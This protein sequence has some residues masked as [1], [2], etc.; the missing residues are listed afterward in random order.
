MIENYDLNPDAYE[1]IEATHRK[2][3]TTLSSMI[4]VLSDAIILGTNYEDDGV[5]RL[6]AS[7]YHLEDLELGL[8]SCDELDY[9]HCPEHLSIQEIEAILSRCKLPQSY[10][11]LFVP[12]AEVLGY[13]LDEGNLYSVGAARL[14]AVIL[15][16]MTFCGF[17]EATIDMER[18]KLDEAAAEAEKHRLLPPEEQ[19]EYFRSADEVFAEM[20][21]K[22][23]FEAPVQNPEE[24]QQQQDDNLRLILRNQLNVYRALKEYFQ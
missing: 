4:P 24:E 9:L 10:S 18:K 14:A 2:V 20:R 5:V 8:S 21:E 19:K 22:F 1:K 17:D 3:L 7:L 12:W 23:G 13:Q 16:E 15:Y 11:F 6:D